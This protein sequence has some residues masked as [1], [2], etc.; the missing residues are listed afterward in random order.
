MSV[1]AVCVGAHPDDVE[2]GMGGTVAGMVRRGLGVM[3]VDLTNGEPTPHGTPE[4]RAAEATEAAAV[5]GCGRVTL[6]LPNRELFDTVEARTALAEVIRELRP[7]MLF[8]PYPVDAHPDHVAAAS[9]AEAA[10]FYGKFTKTPMAGEPHFV[11][12]AYRY[13]AVHLR[14]VAR[15]SFCVDVTADM[16]A[17]AAALRCYRSQFEVNEANAGAI[18]MIEATAAHWGAMARVAAAEPFFALETPCVPGPEAFL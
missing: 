10:R 9:I 12:R 8:M 7:E 13:L 2:I 11:P 15:P 3:I 4:T 5:L 6:D 1:D 14:V 16:A 17:K 18:P